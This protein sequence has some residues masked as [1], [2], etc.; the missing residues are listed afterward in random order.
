M[1]W[2]HHHNIFLLRLLQKHCVCAQTIQNVGQM[3][4]RPDSRTDSK[5]V[6]C[7]EHRQGTAVFWNK[8][9]VFNFLNPYTHLHSLACCFI[10]PFRIIPS[11]RRRI[12]FIVFSHLA[13]PCIRHFWVQK[14]P[15]ISHGYSRFVHNWTLSKAWKQEKTI[16]CLYSLVN[17]MSRCDH[18][19][20]AY[21]RP[22]TLMFWN[23]DVYLMR[24]K[25]MNNY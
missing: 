9:N 3:K 19:V 12:T 13:R 2:N 14:M 18:K 7:G 22:A 23:F 17:A 21:Q 16:F 25:R 20:S 6:C 11:H 8:W 24:G 1:C 10:V 15:V 5:I 4:R